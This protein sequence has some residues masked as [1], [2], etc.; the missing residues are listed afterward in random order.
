[1][2]HNSFHQLSWCWLLCTG[3][4]RHLYVVVIVLNLMLVI[5]W[6]CGCEVIQ[7]SVSVVFDSLTLLN[8]CVKL[9]IFDSVVLPGRVT[10]YEMRL[11]QWFVNICYAF[12]RSWLSESLATQESLRSIARNTPLRPRYIVVVSFTGRCAIRFD[13]F[14]CRTLIKEKNGMIVSSRRCFSGVV[15]LTRFD[16]VCVFQICDTQT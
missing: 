12:C 14:C 7:Y 5:V 4:R 3:T 15:F 9:W 2:C 13:V 11:Y 16:T 1:M 6:F 8:M 10:Q